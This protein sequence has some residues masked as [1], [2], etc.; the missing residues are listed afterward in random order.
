MLPDV[1][2]LAVFTA[3]AITLLV[4][5]GPA[6]LYIVSRSVDQGRAAGL[7]SVAGIHVGTL[8]HVAAAALGLSA[9]LVS[10]ALAY[11]TVRWLGAAYLVFLGIQ[12]LLA[13]DEPSGPAERPPARRGLGR[14]FAQGIVVNVLNPKTALF[15]FAFLPQFVDVH[16]GSVPLQVLVLGVAFVLL[17]VVSD[18][19]YALLAATGA[20]WLRRRPG[21]ARTSRLVSGGVLVTLGLTT[22]LAGSR[23]SSQ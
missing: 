16:R 9:L 17:G 4:I 5:P 11:D 15:F 8:L 21:V 6:V 19:T 23:S 12:R 14:I 3:A 22:A 10:S 20:G 1:S 7:A 13:R 2:T 18:G